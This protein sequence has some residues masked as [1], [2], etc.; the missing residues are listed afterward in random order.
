MRDRVV[1]LHGIGK[2]AS[3]QKLNVTKQH[4]GT[5]S[6]WPANSL[7][8][9][10]RPFCI[11]ACRDSSGCTVDCQTATLVPSHAAEAKTASSY[12]PALVGKT[13]P[14]LGERHTAQRR[15]RCGDAT[16]LGVCAQL[17]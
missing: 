2:D 6:S 17:H 15:H 11:L 10:W 9:T 13:R 1:Y 3:S 7:S 16:N 12:Q 4:Q 5:E 8:G 14:P